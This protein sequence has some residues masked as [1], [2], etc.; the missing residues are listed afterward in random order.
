MASLPLALLFLGSAL[1]PLLFVKPGLEKRESPGV[2]GLLVIIV[3]TT[4]WSLGSA[5]LAVT[6]QPLVWWVGANVRMLGNTLVAVGWVLATAE[7]IG[8]LA[9]N[10]RVVGV[11]LAYPAAIQGLA[12]TN[13]AHGLVYRPLSALVLGSGV[14]AN[15]GPFWAVHII[16]MS[17]GIVVGL[18]FLMSDILRTGGARRKQSLLV[19]ATLAPPAILSLLV[20]FTGLTLPI[21]PTPV[22]NAVGTLFLAWALIRFDAT[23]I[24]P[25][26][27]Y[28]AVERMDDPV[29]TLDADGQIIDSNPA[30]RNLVDA[31]DGWRGTPVE[32]FFEP[33]P[34]LVECFD[35][36]SIDER[37]LT[38]Q[39][40]GQTCSFALN[41]VALTDTDSDGQG[42]LVTLRDI[43]LVKQRERELRERERDLDR[44][45]QLQSRVLRHNL[46]NDLTV[47]RGHVE[48][49]ADELDGDHATKADRVVSKVDDLVSVSA[50]ARDI[51]R[52]IETDQK[53]KQL[54]VANTLRRLVSS[55]RSKFPAVDF[56]VDAPEQCLAE[57]V[58]AVEL[59]I[60]NLLENA[61]KHNDAVNP[62]VE[63][64]LAT[65]EDGVVLTISDN[66]PGIPSNELA[67]LERGEETPLEHGSG[68]GLWVVQWVI[69]DADL[70]VAFDVGPDGT[71]VEVSFPG[72]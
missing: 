38:L 72:P 71:D 29:V 17:G 14:E 46:R 13:P 9:P 58:P 3:A 63:A 37:E 60:Q 11:L 30:A 26:G 50:K 52:L 66:G 22:A 67:V 48:L 40:D 69:E 25:V 47:V 33:Y 64:T 68:I 10:R 32:A 53:S 2:S 49:F 23:D 5:V 62:A 16:I 20:D 55:C 6:Q 44:M 54:D 1:L 36:D 34:D 7:Y 42:Y 59:V 70:S 39:T 4:L 28:Q 15:A 41:S 45:R 24:V 51:E 65:A 18:L 21:D 61:A 27:R 56:S 43:T 8:V 35:G 31:A 19:L 57:T 12:W